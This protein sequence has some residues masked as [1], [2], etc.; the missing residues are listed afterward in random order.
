MRSGYI[1]FSDKQKIGNVEVPSLVDLCV[2]TAIDNI[3]YI[4][5]IAPLDS[6]LLERILPHCTVEQLMHIENATAE[7][8]LSPITDKLWK[9]FYEAKF[10]AE[11]VKVVEA[12]MKKYNVTF[13][14]RQLYQAKLKEVNEAVNVS[15]ERLAQRLKNESARKQTRQIQFC[16][17]VPPSSKRRTFCRAFGESSAYSNAKSSILKKAKAEHFNSAEMKNRAAIRKGAVQQPR[18][19]SIS[20]PQISRG[21]GPNSN[22]YSKGT[23]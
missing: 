12:R 5:N 13:N 22:S 11:S 23:K 21:M 15:V 9:K 4:G 10:F 6:H 20:R 1:H 7:R 3:R 8:D 17:K 2:Q 16:S 18:S 14:W 19:N